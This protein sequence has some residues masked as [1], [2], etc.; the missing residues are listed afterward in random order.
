MGW[1]VARYALMFSCAL[2][3]SL[4]GGCGGGSETSGGG[5]VETPQDIPTLTAIA[6]SSAQ[7]G[8][9]ALS[10]ALFGSN[11]A[12]GAT[13]QWNGAA[14]ASSWVNSTRITAT[15]PAS[16][17][18]SIGTAKV[19]V[20]NPSPGGGTSAA[21]NFTIGTAPVSTTWVRAVPGIATAK[22]IVWDA[23]HGRLYVSI[24]S[25]DTTA[26]NS[27]V[28]IDP[29]T[30]TAGT[31]VPAGNNPD[32]LSISSDASYLWVGLDGANAVQR[33]L[34][35]GLTK[36]ISFPVPLD[37][38]GNAQ[39]PVSLQAARVNPH[40]LA[41]IAGNWGYSPTGNGIYVYDDA[42]QRPTSVPGRNGGGGPMIDWL[43]WGTDDSTIYANQYTTIDAGGVAT[44]NV[45]SSGASLK[46]YFGGEIGP[47]FSQ[48]D[49]GNGRLYSTNRVFNPVDGGQIGQ[50]AVP[51]G[52][53]VCTADSA[54]GRY[55]CVFTN[56]D[57]GTDVSLFELWVYDLNSYALI[58]RVYFGPSAGTP[59]SFVTGGPVSLIRWGN[60]GLALVTNTGLYYGNG[61]VFLIDGSAVNPN[62][63]PDVATGA[64]PWHY[65]WMASIQP[66]QV[67][68]GSGD[69]TVTVQGSS[70]TQDSSACWNCNYLQFQFLPTTYVNAQQLN[71]TVPAS[72]VASA[73]QLPISIFDSSAN[74]FSSDSLSLIVAPVSTAGS[75]TQI[76]AI[77]LAGLAMASDPNGGLLYVGTAEYDGENP[78]A[79]VAVDGTSGSI[80]KTQTVGSNPDVVTISVGGQYL[81]AGYAGAT[82]M[83]QLQLPGLSSPLTW[84]LNN[85]ANSAVY[86]AGDLKASPGSPHTTALTLLNLRSMPDETG[87]VVIYDD[88]VIRPSFAPGFAGGQTVSAFYDVIAWGASDQ[89]LT[90]ATLGGGPLYTFQVTP[91]GPTFLAAGTNS[92]NGGEIHSDFG[93]GLIYSDDGNVADPATQAIVGTYGASG[94]VAPDSSL[95]RVFILGQTAAQANTGNSFTIQSFDE[96]A[97][98]LVSSITLD[99]LLGS[100]IQLV[101]WGTSGLAVLTVNGASGS[102]G[103]LYLVQ[104]ATF[105]TNAAKVATHLSKPQELVQRRWKRISKADLTRMVQARMEAKLP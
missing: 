18:A 103:M 12:S 94:L 40:S 10:L 22:N 20:V 51:T 92:F 27:I 6:P 82:T 37:L 53:R 11:F 60:A 67:A 102:P 48:Y 19:S 74:L 61:G 89:T 47:A 4:L 97:Y 59:A 66:Q 9:A 52:E 81:Y 91:S 88:N 49:K 38:G 65:P 77:G 84:T 56:Q 16:D 23:T 13:V 98:T 21:Q 3:A 42:T 34:L 86:W 32:L 15:I 68:A 73:G 2:L 80:V 14:L 44:V 25:T 36:D 39:Q 55:Y 83:T 31:P 45:T 5:V 24:P 78:N 54:L 46:G 35:P 43:Q 87:G 69:V 79:I 63:P 50:F 64:G 75:K 72:L 105:V 58:E 30:A 28:A 101:R 33:F 99:N 57:N 93:T 100:P 70:F 17:I 71:V 96:K 95:N 26:P 76:K 104:D 29:L 7:A 41:L 8:T 62:A 1:I 90:A 85:P